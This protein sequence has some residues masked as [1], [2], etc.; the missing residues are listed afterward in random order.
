[1]DTPRPDGSDGERIEPQGVL[2]QFERLLKTVDSLDAD[3]ATEED[4]II[5]ECL[6]RAIVAARR[7]GYS[8]DLLVQVL[9]SLI[10]APP[11]V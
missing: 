10:H 1:M 2:G 9:R 5:I 7:K 8:E 6:L 3:R 4:F 11:G